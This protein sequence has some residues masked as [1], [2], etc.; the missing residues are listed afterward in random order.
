MSAPS[1]NGTSAGGGAA[2]F[3]M[4][5]VLHN[6]NALVSQGP[7]AMTLA[8]NVTV[9]D[10]TEAPA[11]E[12]GVKTLVRSDAPIAVAAG[13]VS[14]G[15]P[16][17]PPPWP[18]DAAVTATASVA[19]GSVSVMIMLLLILWVRRR[20][21]GAVRVV[22]FVRKKQAPPSAEMADHDATGDGVSFDTVTPFKDI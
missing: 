19:V 6:T 21:Q 20:P 13:A 17:P 8:F 16:S 22:P 3:N 15:G 14:S 9:T 12:Q 11:I 7:E 4:S 5:A 10:V 1:G 2:S 18:S